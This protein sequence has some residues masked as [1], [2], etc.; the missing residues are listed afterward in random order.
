MLQN[1]Q[2]GN[3]PQ[4]SLGVLLSALSA[5]VCVNI[6]SGK[7]MDFCWQ[8]MRS[9][10]LQALIS[11][12]SCQLPENCLHKKKWIFFC[13]NTQYYCEMNPLY[14]YFLSLSRFF[15]SSWRMC[16]SFTWNEACTK[17]SFFLGFFGS[18]SFKNDCSGD[19]GAA[20]KEFVAFSF[21]D[22]FLSMFWS[23]FFKAFCWQ[24]M[25]KILN[26]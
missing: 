14:F 19:W 17:L 25:Q 11:A 20:L 21:G 15:F 8:Q 12:P 18:Y 10:L 26:H 7:C 24:G 2:V 16:C 1:F 3:A 23:F 22:S 9:A 13:A 4:V 5:S 6:N